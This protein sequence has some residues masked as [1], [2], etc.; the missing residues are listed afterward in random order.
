MRR[1]KHPRFYRSVFYD[2]MNLWH[3][4]SGN[5]GIRSPCNVSVSVT[6]RLSEEDNTISHTE[7]RANLICSLIFPGAQRG[8]TRA[9]FTKT[10]STRQS[11]GLLFT[12]L[13]YRRRIR[14]E[15][16]DK[17]WAANTL[18]CIITGETKFRSTGHL[19]FGKHLAQ[20]YFLVSRGGQV[21]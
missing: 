18:H 15:L 3:C 8:T 5:T 7:Y 12:R 11:P 20:I 10:A 14:A 6:K 1:R 13:C 9:L 19:T 2:L 4:I 16:E 17:R 21:H